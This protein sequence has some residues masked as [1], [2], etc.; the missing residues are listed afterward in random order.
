M[1]KRI[2]VD[3]EPVLFGTGMTNRPTIRELEKILDEEEDT[4]IEILPNGEVRPL[5]THADELHGGKPLTLREDLGGEYGGHLSRLYREVEDARCN[6]PL[7]DPYR[8]A[9]GKLYVLG[10]LQA[11]PGRMYTLSVTFPDTYPN[12]PPHVGV[13]K[14]ALHDA[15]PHRYR[16]GEICYLHPKMWNPGLHNLTFVIGRAAK[17][18]GKYEVWLQTR[19]WPGAQMSHAS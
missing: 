15:A 10:A 8:T 12:S 4:P 16:D 17:W 9:E 11:A 5:G 19:N 1:A 6:F 7:I 2:N 3:G 13:R 18:L 14:P